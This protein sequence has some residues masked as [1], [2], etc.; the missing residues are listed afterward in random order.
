MIGPFSWKKVEDRKKCGKNGGIL[1]PL[2]N[3]ISVLQ[4][5]QVTPYPSG[6]SY[7]NDEIDNSSGFSKIFA[8]DFKDFLSD[9]VFPLHF[10]LRIASAGEGGIHLSALF[11]HLGLG[12][13]HKFCCKHLGCKLS[14]LA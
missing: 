13:S 6:L 7:T 4:S 8:M 2:S 5:S 1:C 11:R 10:L 9:L 3:C 14:L 12:S